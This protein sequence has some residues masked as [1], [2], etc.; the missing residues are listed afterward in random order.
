MFLTMVVGILALYILS[1]IWFII[2]PNYLY[3]LI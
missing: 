3:Y 2:L 1:N